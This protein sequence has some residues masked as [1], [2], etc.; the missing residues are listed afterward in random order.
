MFLERFPDHRFLTIC[1]G[2]LVALFLDSG[3]WVAP[4]LAF[5]FLSL[6]R[7]L[8]RPLHLHRHSTG[9]AGARLLSFGSYHAPAA[10]GKIVAPST[11]LLW[12]TPEGQQPAV[13]APVGCGEVCP[14]C[15]RLWSWLVGRQHPATLQCPGRNGVST[16]PRMHRVPEDLSA[17]FDEA[18]AL[19]DDPQELPREDNPGGWLRPAPLDEDG[20]EEVVVAVRRP[21]PPP[22]PTPAT[23]A[24][25]VVDAVLE[26]VEVV[27]ECPSTVAQA[28]QLIDDAR[29]H[30]RSLLY[31]HLVEVVP[32]P[33]ETWGTFLAVPAWCDNEALIVFD[34]TDFDG[35]F[36]VDSVPWVA[37]RAQL[38]SIAGV[39]LSPNILIYAFGH[40]APLDDEDLHVYMGGCIFFVPRWL[41]ARIGYGLPW[42]LRT[43]RIWDQAAVLPLSLEGRFLCCV[44]DGG[45]RCF[46]IRPDRGNYVRQDLPAEFGLNQ[47]QVTYQVSHPE[48]DDAV[49]KGRT[50]LAVLGVTTEIWRTAQLVGSS[51]GASA[52]AL[53]D[54]RP[55]LQGWMSIVVEG[56]TY[57]HSELVDHL[58]VFAP[59]G[60][61]VQ[62]DGAPVEN[63]DFQLDRGRLLQAQFVP[64]TTDEEMDDGTEDRPDDTSDS[65][66]DSSDSSD[67]SSQ[68][69]GSDAEGPCRDCANPGDHSGGGSTQSRSRS[70]SRAPREAFQAVPHIGGCSEIMW[71]KRFLQ[72]V[73]RP[74]SVWITSVLLCLFGVMNSTRF[75]RSLPW[76]SA[77]IGLTWWIGVA[78]VLVRSV[79]DAS[80]H[81]RR[82]RT[83]FSCYGRNEVLVVGACILV[84]AQFAGAA[85]VQIRPCGVDDCVAAPSSCPSLSTTAGATCNDHL[86]HIEGTV[87]A[88]ATGG[89]SRRPLP[90]PCRGTHVPPID[91]GPTLL[92]ECRQR[93]G[94]CFYLEAVAVLE[95]LFE[96]F[97]IDPP[98]RQH[99]STP[100][101]Q[102]TLSL[103]EAVPITPFQREVL[104]LQELLPSR[105]REA[106]SQDWL[107]NDL[108]PLLA[109]PSVPRHK[110]VLFQSIPCWHHVRAEV[111]PQA[112]VI[113]SDGSASGDV[114]TDS[115]CISPGSWAFSVWV[116]AD[117]EYLV[118]FASCLRAQP[119]EAWYVG[120]NDDTAITCEI[121]G[122]VWG[123]VWA[124]EFA[125]EYG[126][127][128]H[129]K[130]D[131]LS[132][133][134]GTFGMQAAVKSG[135]TGQPTQLALFACLL[136][137][138]VA[139]RLP[140]HHGHV[141][142]HSGHIANE[143]C[144][145][146]AKRIRRVGHDGCFTLLPEWPRKLFEHPCRD[147][148]WLSA[149]GSSDMPTLFVFEAEAHRL[150]GIPQAGVH[151]PSLGYT[152][153]TPPQ[154][155]ARYLFKFMTCNVLTLLDPGR[156]AGS[157][158][159]EPG[160]GLAVVAKREVIKT[161]LLDRGI[162]FAGFQE[163]R[164]RQ[165][166][167][168]PD[169]HFVML[170][171]SA[172][173]KRHYG[174]ALWANKQIPYATS[175][176]KDLFLEARHCTHCHCLCAKVHDSASLSA[177]VMLDHSGRSRPF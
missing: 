148:A 86:G 134:L 143:L 22:T 118:G 36:F 67:S 35:R 29:D 8:V 10:F 27:L 5:L 24:I 175:N 9:R 43:P 13:L 71:C 52:L 76:G 110:R 141:R 172:T 150:Q 133:G 155:A 160:R 111:Q 127:P 55:L 115:C 70:P 121:L 174:M 23:F 20:D 21:G 40:P 107:D 123:L 109:D 26:R 90:T 101:R 34:L 82:C 30:D 102:P 132:A 117:K 147:W 79:P 105:P 28:K 1:W 92:E 146:L 130:Y 3:D 58:S 140:L 144:D 16:A 2:G 51:D 153:P 154:A 94:D 124:W 62:V 49:I 177:F 112:L 41:P 120:E 68:G 171:S 163:T 126:L 98:V 167:T 137:Q 157:A 73:C 54:C 61:Q 60:W 129:C 83:S 63:G 139:T 45:H 152:K 69:D 77:A 122:I 97:A 108:A 17:A 113:Y 80:R 74:D 156:Q 85:A 136:R 138:C 65:D 50:C 84:C 78:T 135:D 39:D 7:P 166:A 128:V 19:E 89:V 6:L 87:N 57:S 142:A 104:S 100:A 170:H 38:F 93:A 31:P 119:H 159:A 106:D 64:L 59:A 47:A 4:A 161:Q 11:P 72:H 95:T 15:D 131:C 103:A 44:L 33:C 42:M 164:L 116:L 158:S 88:P 37:N 99:A 151:A 56:G 66:A 14:P 162:L 48:V 176:G 12:W 53:V 114:E 169:R 165:T 173:D 125:A 18:V 75:C 145:E 81:K 25:L 46:E 96:H 32:Q 149:S 91:V 168:L